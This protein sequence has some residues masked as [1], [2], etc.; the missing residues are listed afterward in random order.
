MPHF[1]NFHILCVKSGCLTEVASHAI[2]SFEVIGPFRVSQALLKSRKSTFG[3]Y[4]DVVNVELLEE[5]VSVFASGVSGAVDYFVPPRESVL[6]DGFAVGF[7]V[8]LYLFIDALA[9]LVVLIDLLFLEFGGVIKFLADDQKESEDELSGIALIV[10]LELV[11]LFPHHFLYLSWVKGFFVQP[12]LSNECLEQIG[13]L[14]SAT[15]SSVLF[16]DFLS[17]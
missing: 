12:H 9:R 17:K 11:V 5:S 4:F 6:N 10:V 3:W 13:Q 1:E 16:F 8:E 7:L 2:L 14:I 15:L